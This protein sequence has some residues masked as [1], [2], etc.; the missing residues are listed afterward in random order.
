MRL[1]AFGSVD[2]GVLLSLGTS[3]IV[4]VA[5][6]QGEV[7][8]ALELLLWGLWKARGKGKQPLRF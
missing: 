3:G 2:L 5:P 1:A 8:M 4:L 7:R 6:K